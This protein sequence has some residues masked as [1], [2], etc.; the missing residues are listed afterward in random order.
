M[1]ANNSSQQLHTRTSN[2]GAKS[3]GMTI[4]SLYNV[5]LCTSYDK[6]ERS[7]TNDAVAA[8]LLLGDAHAAAQ[9]RAQCPVMIC[10]VRI[11]VLEFLELF[12]ESSLHY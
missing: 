9:T 1:T 11:G 12:V 4:D 2:G 8:V 3:A 10:R 6:S 7:N 5:I